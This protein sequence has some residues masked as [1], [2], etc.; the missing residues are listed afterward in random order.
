MVMFLLPL[1]D[2]KHTYRT[3]SIDKSSCFQFCYRTES[4]Y[5]CLEKIFIF[6]NLDFLSCSL[7][8]IWSRNKLLPTGL[9]AIRFHK[10]E[11]SP[12]KLRL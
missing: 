6:S 8:S 3:E 5:D 10:Q 7:R 1:V 9:K 12:A 2:L 4:D 11:Y